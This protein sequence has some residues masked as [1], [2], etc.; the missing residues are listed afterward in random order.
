MIFDSISFLFDGEY[1]MPG[2]VSPAAKQA[3]VT[4]MYVK[5][6]STYYT[7][8]S[9][10]I[11]SIIVNFIHNA[12]IFAHSGFVKTGL[13]IIHISKV[14]VTLPK[15]MIISYFVLVVQKN[16]KVLLQ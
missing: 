16:I 5:L 12:L 9:T 11:I 15:C 14:I 2:N 8:T 10:V 1:I 3:L 6:M 4:V 7:Y 13:C